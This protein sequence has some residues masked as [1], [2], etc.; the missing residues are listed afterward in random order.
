MTNHLLRDLAPVSPAAW[1]EIEDE[2]RRSLETFLAA[3]KLVDFA[4]PKGWDHAAEPTGRT[5]GDVPPL[6][7]DVLTGLRQ[8]RPLVEL[9]VPFTLS[10]DELDAIERG[11]RDV[12]LGPVVAAAR[13]LATAEDRAV[14][15]GFDAAGIR[16]VAQASPHR[17]ITITDDYNEYPALVA[18][19][20]NGLRT[21]GVGGPYA[22]ALGPRCY[23]GVV[24]GTEKGGYPVLEHLHLIV[25]GPVVWAP[26]V[27]GAVVMS[28]RGGD[29][30]L[31]IG[32]D[33][34]IGFT[35]ASA[36]AVDLYLEETL[37]FGNHSPEAAVALRY[38]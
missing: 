32:E 37:T 38:G 7:A 12:D 22:L 23:I 18:K 19:A 30:Q 34:S 21:A 2:A 36:T 5:T 1:G 26:A 31:T 4:G 10:R 28:Q 24:E 16:G 25:G 11:A 29:F 33:V 15:Y 27:D 3:R 8:A 14:F 35:A 6:A 13:A 20:V 17:A 9:R